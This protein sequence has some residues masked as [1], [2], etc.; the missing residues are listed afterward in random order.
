MPFFMPA[1]TPQVI[2]LRE[3]PP[4]ERDA[5]LRGLMDLN[6]SF[7]PPQVWDGGRL[8][9]TGSGG[10]REL[11]RIQPLAQFGQ[12]PRDMAWHFTFDIVEGA[13]Y[14][15]GWG[16]NLASGQKGKD[17]Q[18]LRRTLYIYRNAGARWELWDTLKS[19]HPA[20]IGWMRPLEGGG[21]LLGGAFQDAV[22]DRCDPLAIAK[23]NGHGVTRILDTED[24]KLGAPAFVWGQPDDQPLDASES[25]AENY[26][27]PRWIHNRKL[28]GAYDALMGAFSH[29]IRVPGHLVLVGRHLGIFIVINSRTGKVERTEKLFG[30]LPDDAMTTPEAYEYGVLGVQ[31]RP[32]GHL[33]IAARSEDAVVQSRTWK[34]DLPSPEPVRLSFTEAYGKSTEDQGDLLEEK[35]E[36]ADF[37]RAAE[38]RETRLR[39]FSDL[40]WWDFD[41]D[42]G[43]FRREPSPAGVPEKFPSCAALKAFSFAFKPDGNLDIQP[44]VWK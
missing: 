27:R 14:A 28:L 12:P 13:A 4:S 33:L 2:H 5:M 24:A 6:P 42:T 1:Q 36:A 22:M 8:F 30:D 19:T 44:K 20:F 9:E 21:Y 37:A 40:V 11:D 39:H 7:A 18:E 43:A 35:Q 41:P 23:N 25:H 3:V 15:W 10:I 38:L 32:D 17:L 26:N 29:P 16:E 31:P 34:P